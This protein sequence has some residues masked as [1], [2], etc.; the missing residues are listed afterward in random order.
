MASATNHRAAE[1]SQDSAPGC[2]LV[3]AKPPSEPPQRPPS[4]RPIAEHPLCG[5]NRNPQLQQAPPKRD[6]TSSV[7]R[8]SI[9][10]LRNPRNDTVNRAAA[11]RFSIPKPRGPRLRLNRLLCASSDAQVLDK[12]GRWCNHITFD[13]KLFDDNPFDN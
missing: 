5:P 13:I 12:S 8:A 10:A 9:K 4:S 6:P 11:N 7:S 1:R 2:P 3:H